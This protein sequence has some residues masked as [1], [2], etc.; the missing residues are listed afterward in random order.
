VTCSL[1]SYTGAPAHLYRL[2]HAPNA[3]EFPDWAFA[4]EGGTF[5]NRWDDPQSLYR[6]LYA[7]AQ[8][9]G[10]FLETLARFRPDAQ[11]AAG[12]DEIRGDEEALPGPGF[13]PRRW[14]A[15]RVLG[16]ADSMGTYALVGT[17]RSLEYLRIAR[18]GTA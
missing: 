8:R 10:T 16:E 5:G 7:S 13:L 18:A 3:W 11:V 4:R 17:A 15:D 2:A 1:D 12:L 14:I 6:V 9:V